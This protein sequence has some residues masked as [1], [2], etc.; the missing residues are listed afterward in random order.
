MHAHA[1]QPHL[2]GSRVE[3]LKLQITQVT[4]IHG[5]SPLAAKTL[6]VKMMGTSPYLLIRI[7]SHAYITMLYL[8][9][10]SQIAHGLHDFRHA[11]LVIGSQQGSAICHYDILALVEFQFGELLHAGHYTGRQRDILAIIIAYDPCLHVFS[12]TIG[13]GIIMGDKSDGRNFFLGI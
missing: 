12:A 6:H 2:G 9:M 1:F 8:V 5:I 4:A 11:S 10:V 7:E 13:A 3:I